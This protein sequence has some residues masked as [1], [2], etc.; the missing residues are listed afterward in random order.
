VSII[1]EEFDASRGNC[2]RNYMIMGLPGKHAP[3]NKNIK[4]NLRQQPQSIGEQI[5]M[6]FHL[7]HHT[8][9]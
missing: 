4:K 8:K 1:Q 9:A 5:K 6:F 3:K 7:S 2:I